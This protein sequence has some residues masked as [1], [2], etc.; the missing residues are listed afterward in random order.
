MR[1]REMALSGW[2]VRRQLGGRGSQQARPAM[3]TAVGGG[4]AAAAVVGSLGCRCADLRA[5]RQL[6]AFM[7]AVG[8]LSGSMAQRLEAQ[9]RCVPPS[10]G[11]AQAIAGPGQRPCATDKRLYGPPQSQA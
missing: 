6:Q 4:Q 9:R 10:T 11:S 8:L 3:R 1:E 2:V 5:A 7:L